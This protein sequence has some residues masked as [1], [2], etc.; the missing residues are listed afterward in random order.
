MPIS[1][2]VM[3]MMRLVLDFLRDLNILNYNPNNMRNICLCLWRG[4]RAF[5]LVQQAQC[6]MMAGR[7][8]LTLSASRTTHTQFINK[9]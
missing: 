6:T 9:S 5:P 7:V 8:R 1:G 4:N 2:Y 3:R